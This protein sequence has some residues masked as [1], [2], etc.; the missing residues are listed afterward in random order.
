MVNLNRVLAPALLAASTVA[1]LLSS[2]RPDSKVA[3]NVLEG[4]SEGYCS[5]RRARAR[6]RVIYTDLD[7]TPQFI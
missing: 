2:A 3:R 5:V 4:K 7:A 6:R 1:A